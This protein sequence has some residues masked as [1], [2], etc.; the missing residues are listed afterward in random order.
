MLTWSIGVISLSPGQLYYNDSLI[1]R[2]FR[3]IFDCEVSSP[4]RFKI[5]KRT[6]K[7]T[8]LIS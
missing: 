2:L 4:R 7:Q 6:S 5:K 3:N 8:N 1:L